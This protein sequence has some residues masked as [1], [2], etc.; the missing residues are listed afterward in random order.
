MPTVTAQTS[1]TMPRAHESSPLRSPRDSDDVR[2]QWRRANQS[3]EQGNSDSQAIA[4]L[5]RKVESMRRRILG[6]SATT[7]EGWHFEDGIEVDNTVSYPAQSVIHIQ[8][9]HS[10]VVTGI[11]DAA[12]PGSGLVKSQQGFWVATQDVPAK[13]V[14]SGNDVWNLPQYPYPEPT[15]LDDPTNY[16]IFLGDICP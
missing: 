3:N 7:F 12:D 2:R 13:T 4:A 16:W 11:R 1:I 5:A 14:V 15:D 10:L 6:G 9:T 8:P